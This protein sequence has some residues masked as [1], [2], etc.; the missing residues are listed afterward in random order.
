MQRWARLL[1]EGLPMPRTFAPLAAA[2]LLLLLGAGLGGV[3][4][5]QGSATFDG[6]Y[7]G[8]LTLRGVIGGD[9]TPP[10]LGAVYPLTVSRGEVRFAYVPRFSTTLIGRVGADGSFKASA[11]MKHGSVQM[12][13]HIQGNN[14]TATILSPS[15]NYTFQTRN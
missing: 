6:Q 13:G 1:V 2:F 7:V 5:A 4:W 15:C 9:C 11:R 3:A 8:E 14:A 10:P 12:T